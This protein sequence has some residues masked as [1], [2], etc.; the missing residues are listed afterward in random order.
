MLRETIGRI[1]VRE[2]SDRVL[3]AM[4]VTE[5]RVTPDLNHARVFVMC[6]RPEPGEEEIGTEEN[7]VHAAETVQKLLAPQIRLKRTPSLR[8]E[9]DDTEEQAE[10]VERL[11]DQ[12][13]EDWEDA[14]RD[15]EC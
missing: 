12:V 13:R 4:T 2:T 10:R 9:I 5:V 1:M 8:F 11:L 7:L 6:R 15:P 14:D 3:A